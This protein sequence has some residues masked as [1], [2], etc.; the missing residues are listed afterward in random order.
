MA[1]LAPLHAVAKVRIHAAPHF[2]GGIF[3]TSGAREAFEKGGAIHAESQS[4][5]E[6]ETSG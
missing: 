3:D 4:A 1:F 6:N 2:S 5:R